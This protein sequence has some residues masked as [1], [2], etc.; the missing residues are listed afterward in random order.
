MRRIFHPLLQLLAY[1][2]RQ[3]LARQVQ[4]LK[5]E[6][7]ILRSKLPA[8]ITIK[9]EERRQLVKAGRGLGKAI[10][11]LISIVKPA[12]FLGWV[13]R[14]RGPKAREK[15]S[16][17]KPGRPRTPD[18]VRELIVRIANETG[19]GY[20]KPH[21][22]YAPLQSAEQLSDGVRGVVSSCGK[23]LSD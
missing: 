13:N 17:R 7:Q 23:G 10:W 19:W 11:E 20:T 16:T 21:S 3:E 4:Y 18:D 8:R 1:A 12:T 14:E 2:T 15:K 9:P 6:N 5:T 22:Q